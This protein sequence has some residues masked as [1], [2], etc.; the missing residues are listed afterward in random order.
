M[1]IFERTSI[2]STID[3]VRTVHLQLH[4]LYYTC[5]LLTILTK[6]LYFVYSIVQ[7]LYETV[8]G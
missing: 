2:V 8:D 1:H 6:L 3:T 5:I 4:P 7:Y